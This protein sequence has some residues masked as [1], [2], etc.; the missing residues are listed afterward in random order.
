MGSGGEASVRY[1]GFGD[2]VYGVEVRA[3]AGVVEILTT[4]ERAAIARALGGTEQEHGYLTVRSL[5]ERVNAV[6]DVF[7][8]NL[9]AR[10]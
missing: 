7:G 9:V 1:A 5:V 6:D 3:F 8:A 4:D 2:A 10:L